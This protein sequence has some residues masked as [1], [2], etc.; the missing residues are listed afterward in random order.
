MGPP[1]TVPPFTVGWDDREEFV[2]TLIIGMLMPDPVTGERGDADH[3]EYVNE[4]TGHRTFFYWDSDG[5]HWEDDEPAPATDKVCPNCEG[6]GLYYIK[7]NPRTA[8]PLRAW[9]IV[10]GKDCVTCRGT[11]RVILEEERTEDTAQ[12]E[13]FGG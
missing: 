13:E 1:D 2:R 5:M 10:E 9:K 11:G 6:T 4:E 7:R 3:G 12:E 8:K